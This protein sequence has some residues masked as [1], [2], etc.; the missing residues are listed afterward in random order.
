MSTNNST[1]GRCNVVVYL[2]SWPEMIYWR[3]H[4]IIHANNIICAWRLDDDTN[5][6][7]T[8]YNNYYYNNYNNIYNN[9]YK[10]NDATRKSLLDNRLVDEAAAAAAAAEEAA[11]VRPRRTHR[12]TVSPKSR[13][14]SKSRSPSVNGQSSIHHPNLPQYTIWVLSQATMTMTMCRRWL[15]RR[16]QRRR[17]WQHYHQY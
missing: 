13:Y 2:G 5:N 7:N 6:Y 9:Y 11:K 1:Y 14:W 3:Y 15:R 4:E 10:K 17:R 12:R 8:N 16:R